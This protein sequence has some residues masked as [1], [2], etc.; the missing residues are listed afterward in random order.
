MGEFIVSVD[1][2]EAADVRALLGQHLS[3]AR[4]FTRPEDCHALDI[5]SLLSE[6]VTLFSLREK[7]TL[8]GVG[9]LR[10]LD[11]LHV[12]LKSMHTAEAARHRGV[13]RA[14]V[15]HLVGVARDRGFARVSLETAS[16]EAFA[17][18]RAL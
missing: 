7:G 6:D 1:R 16:M 18:S 15:D 14:L 12:E 5:D 4:R 8:L 10:Q 17:P 9:A 13:G 11:D 2:P 3:F